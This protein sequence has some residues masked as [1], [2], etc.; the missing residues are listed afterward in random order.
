M[1]VDLS[2]ELTDLNINFRE[3]TGGI[4]RD[5]KQQSYNFAAD[6]FAIS[7]KT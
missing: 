3:V 5:L 7:G 2:L 6:P 1:I 4:V